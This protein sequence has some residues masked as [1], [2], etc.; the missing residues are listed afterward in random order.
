MSNKFQRNYSLTVIGSGGPLDF[1]EIS[2]PFTIEFDIIRN[3]YASA[4]TSSIR[5]Y[6]L[7]EDTRN[8]IRKDRWETTVYKDIILAA[9]YGTDYLTTIF[10]GNISQAWSVREG[11]NMITQIESY[12]GG[13]AFAASTSNVNFVKGTPYVAMILR[14]MADLNKVSIGEIGK[15][16]GVILK[17]NTYS[18]NTP[19]LLSQLT[20][21]SFFID[22]QVAHCLG[23]D[24][25]LTPNLTDIFQINS[26]M[27]LLGTPIKEEQYYVFDILFEPRL[28]IGQQIQIT[29][30]T[31]SIV[32]SNTYKVVGIKHRGMISE[33]VCGEAKTTV[34][35]YAINN[36]NIGV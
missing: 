4:N 11:N 21:Q 35:V 13:E 14:L 28:R 29:S 7:A 34:E 2:P 3:S 22:N 1:V 5:I 15:F 23:D 10:A 36:P 8:K 18:G 25:T 19:H 12:D 33:A 26:S 16:P 9:G 6:N 30:T 31:N 17:G 27:G 24:E 32:N 20:G